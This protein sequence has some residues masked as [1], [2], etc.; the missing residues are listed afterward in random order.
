MSREVF[1]VLIFLIQNG[2]DRRILGGV[3]TETAAVKRILCLYLGVPFL[4]L[5]I[6]N[7]LGSQFVDKIR[8]RSGGFLRRIRRLN[9]FVDIIGK[10]FLILR[11]GNIPLIEHIGQY[12]FAALCIFLRETDR[13]VRVR[14]LRDCSQYG[15]FGQRQ[16]FTVFSKIPLCCRLYPIGSG[17]EVDGIQIIFQDYAFGVHALCGQGS[18]QLKR[19]ILLLDLTFETLDLPLVRPVGKYVVFQ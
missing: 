6:G 1:F 12:L 11:F 8:I 16:V 9:P 4:L 7:D 3:D 13:V 2:L 15:T 18:L 14:V 17:G 19:Q 5:Q 10:R